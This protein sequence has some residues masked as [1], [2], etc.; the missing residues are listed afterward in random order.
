[1]FKPVNPKQ[2]FPELEGEITKFW[3]ENKI[4]EKSVE[5]RNAKNSYI[6]YDLSLIHI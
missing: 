5:N 6:F 3:K 2:N 4:F 1:M